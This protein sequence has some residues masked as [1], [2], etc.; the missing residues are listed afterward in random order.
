MAQGPEGGLQGL[1]G[2][3]H[4]VTFQQGVGAGFH[5]DGR[6]LFR[7]GRFGDSDP[8]TPGL[9]P[10]PWPGSAGRSSQPCGSLRLVDLFC[11]WLEDASVF[12]KQRPPGWAFSQALSHLCPRCIPWALIS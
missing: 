4:R 2:R 7:P 5:G 1:E 9:R 6:P 3:G 10:R 8:R 11:S 12:V